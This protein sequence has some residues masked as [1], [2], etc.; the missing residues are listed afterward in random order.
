MDR[1]LCYLLNKNIEKF[2]ER[3]ADKYFLSKDPELKLDMYF[4][5][6]E[7]S[8]DINYNLYINDYYF[9]IDDIFH[10]LWYDIPFEIIDERY[11][12]RSDINNEDR[13]KVWNLKNFY[14]L[15]K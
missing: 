4:I 5:E 14:L 12:L 6:W 3:F 11:D 15:K 9:S 13:D 10:A 8:D 7:H 2:A 1:D